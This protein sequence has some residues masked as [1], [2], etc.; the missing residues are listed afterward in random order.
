LA[1]HSK[2]TAE[3]VNGQIDAAVSADEQGPMF[4]F[5]KY[6]R[7]EGISVP[8]NKTL[9]IVSALLLVKLSEMK[10]L[11]KLDESYFVHLVLQ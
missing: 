3:S 11:K 2:I 5:L 6:C 4:W 8:R 10:R 7:F 1:Q 9:S